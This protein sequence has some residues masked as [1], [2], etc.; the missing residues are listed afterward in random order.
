MNSFLYVACAFNRRARAVIAGTLLLPVQVVSVAQGISTIQRL[1]VIEVPV[2]S[3][4]ANAQAVATLAL[5]GQGSRDLAHAI[6]TSAHIGPSKRVPR[7]R[8]RR[9][10]IARR[11]LWNGVAR[12]HSP[13]H[14]E[15]QSRAPIIAFI[16]E[17]VTSLSARRCVTN[18]RANV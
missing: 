17:V 2:E 10:W 6:A 18:L 5:R 3:L 7:Q 12:A 9:C 1:A 13:C 14:W 8:S 15:G 4:A 11:K 16:S